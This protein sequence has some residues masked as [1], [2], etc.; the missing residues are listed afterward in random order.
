[1]QQ[2]KNFMNRKINIKSRYYLD[3]RASGY[4]KIK[5]WRNLS[6]YHKPNPTPWKRKIAYYIINRIKSTVVCMNGLY[7]SC[8]YVWLEQAR[9][10]GP[11]T[12]CHRER[13][14]CL[15]LTKSLLSLDL[16]FGKKQIVDPQLKQAVKSK[17]SNHDWFNA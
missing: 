12:A 11:S 15:H 4:L 13:G 2:F 10:R 5:K 1:M 6:F 16:A 3:I 14:H 7:G 9:A 17:K 8:R